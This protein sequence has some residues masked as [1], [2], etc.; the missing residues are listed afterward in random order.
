MHAL[1]EDTVMGNNI[2]SVTGHEHPLQVG[3]ERKLGEPLPVPGFGAKLKDGMIEL[4]GLDMVC[5]RL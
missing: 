5:V 4:D 1:V 2:G 3:I